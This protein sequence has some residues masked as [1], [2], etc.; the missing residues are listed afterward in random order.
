MLDLVVDVAR[1]FESMAIYDAQE[2]RYNIMV[3]GP[4]EFHDA[5]RDSLA[6][7]F[8]TRRTPTFCSPGSFAAPQL[9]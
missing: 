3:M 9:W 1:C 6:R 2:D 4:D 8:G 5:T 7:G